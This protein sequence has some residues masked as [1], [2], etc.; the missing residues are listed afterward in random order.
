M[1][2]LC[3]LRRPV[4]AAL[5][6]VV[7]LAAPGC[8]TV[9]AS[10]V[11]P[12][13]RQ[14][15]VEALRG[16]LASPSA[17]ARTEAAHY[18]LA[19]DY[20]TG[21]RDAFADDLASS[22]NKPHSRIDLWGVLALA[23]ARPQ[24][25]ATWIEKIEKVWE[26]TSA[27]DRLV[28]L[29]TLA[30]LGVYPASLRPESADDTFDSG[31]LAVYSDWIRAT[32]G[33][34]K[35]ES[36]VA[37]LL[38]ASEPAVRAR[39]GYV[40]FQLPE[41]SPETWQTLDQAATREPATTLAGAFLMSAA[42]VHAPE[43]RRGHW[44]DA[45][46]R[47]GLRGNQRQRYQLGAA[48]ARAGVD[49]D[50]PILE[51][52]LTD[53]EPG[54]RAAAANAILRIGRRVPHQ[55]TWLDW[56]A[57]A[58]YGTG[59]LLVGWYYSRRVKTTE[60]YLLGGRNMRP[61]AVGLSLFATLLSTLSYVAWPGEIIKHG[62]MIASGVIAS[63]FVVMVVGWVLIPRIMKLRVTSAYEI[64]QA[65]LGPSIRMMGALIFLTIRLF[66]MAAIIY[67]TSSKILL[68]VLGIDE[69]WHPWDLHHSRLGD[70]RLHLDGGSEG[71]GIH[72]RGADVHSGGRRTAHAG[73]DHHR[74][75]RGRRLVAHR[76]A[77]IVA[78]T[79]V[80]L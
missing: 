68:P 43:D 70:P 10:A 66:W 8:T 72:R 60:D 49:S 18:L 34:A 67:A 5:C 37:A 48:L 40:L 47:H 32:N 44:R 50:L 7:A 36:S 56:A 35:A 39:A 80:R 29:E 6:S 20:P 22:G 76:V 74:H 11:T 28:A 13:L 61:W 17:T 12:E 59:M 24:E 25:R 41:V 62:P 42:F 77:G 65:R 16:T 21:V 15:A 63:P 53:T 46:V 19:L 31:P 38:N 45:F 27:P 51:E 23:A 64:L 1:I 55:M 26:D 33:V 57:I 58:L 79:E 3:P 78:G 75:G 52:L 14:R 9:N 69:S 73:N 4:V 54:V 30:K 71:C 2:A